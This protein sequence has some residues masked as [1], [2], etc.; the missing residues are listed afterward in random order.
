MRSPLW[1]HGYR[2]QPGLLARHLAKDQHAPQ[3]DP[4]DPAEGRENNKILPYGFIFH[5]ISSIV[6]RCSKERNINITSVWFTNRS[7]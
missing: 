4:D 6:Q 2:R 7:R 3:Q 5:V 1:S